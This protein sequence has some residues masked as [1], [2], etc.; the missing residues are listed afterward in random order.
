MV[1]VGVFT[2]GDRP[3]LIITTLEALSVLVARKLHHGEQPRIN[4]IHIMVVPTCS[5]SRGGVARTKPRRMR[6][7]ALVDWSPLADSKEAD[8]PV[9]GVCDAFQPRASHPSIF[10]RSGER[11]SYSTES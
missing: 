8:S 3:F 11:S 5:D 1:W 2:T 9:N 6:M 10:G 7:K 4:Q